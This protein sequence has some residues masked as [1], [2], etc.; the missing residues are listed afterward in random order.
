[1]LRVVLLVA[2]LLGPATG[3]RRGSHVSGADFPV[4][5][6]GM[7]SEAS[8]ARWV[9]SRSD[10]MLR[11]LDPNAPREG[12][13]SIGGDMAS[14]AAVERFAAVSEM[15]DQAAPGK[16]RRQERREDRKERR[17]GEV[18]QQA[19]GAAAAAD[20]CGALVQA[21]FRSKAEADGMSTD[22]CRNTIIVELGKLPGMTNLQA[23]SNADLIKLGAAA[24]AEKAKRDGAQSPA[25]TTTAAPALELA[26]Q[27]PAANSSI[28]SAPADTKCPLWNGLPCGGNGVCEEGSCVCETGFSGFDCSKRELWVEGGAGWGGAGR[29]GVGRRQVGGSVRVGACAVAAGGGVAVVR[30]RR[31]ELQRACCGAP[32]LSA[33]CGRHLPGPRAAGC[34]GLGGCWGMAHGGGCS[35]TLREL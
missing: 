34:C 24:L 5:Q 35:T 25:N 6:A 1:M 16:E 33:V 11:Q 20:V 15:A 17:G 27:A 7:E 29:G 21:G 4:L 14:R 31:R 23:K 10:D 28:F 26:P 12:M 9:A 19:Q 8:R 30:R 32:L 13:A 3:V 2:A 22:D 18:A